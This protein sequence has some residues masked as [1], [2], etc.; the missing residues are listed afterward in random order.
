MDAAD[1][2][3]AWRLTKAG[4]T[5]GDPTIR[6]TQERLAACAY[7]M[8]HPESDESVP[9]CVQHSILDPDETSVLAELL[10][11]VAASALPHPA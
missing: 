2:R 8:A 9:A 3:E 1:V 11:S 7:G 4:E 10:L 6:E 5:I